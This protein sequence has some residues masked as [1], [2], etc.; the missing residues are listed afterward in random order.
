[1]QQ[2]SRSKLKKEG[3]SMNRFRLGLL[4]FMACVFILIGSA[5][6]AEYSGLW[7]GKVTINAVSEVNRREPDLSFD[8]GMIGV[9]SEN[10]FIIKGDTWNYNDA[11]SEPGIDGNSKNWKQTGYNDSSWSSGD[12]ALGYGAGEFTTVSYGPDPEQKYPTTYFRKCFTVDDP[13]AY[14][15]LNLY[16]WRDDGVIVYL[17]GEEVLRNNLSP[18]YVDFDTLA[19]S[20]ITENTLLQLTIPAG[21][22][23]E[24][25]NCIAAEVHLANTNDEDCLFDLKLAGILKDPETTELIPLESMDW[26][27]HHSQWGP[28]AASETDPMDTDWHGTAYDDNGWDTGQAQFGYG[29]GDETTELISGTELKPPTAYFRRAFSI[30]LSLFT[31]L[32]LLLLQDDG[33][34]VYINGHEVVRENL[35]S[36]TIT[37]TTPPIK[38]L[39]SADEN[40]YVVREIDLSGAAGLDLQPPPANNIVA[41]EVHQ[42]P[43]EFGD[44][45]AAATALTRTPAAFDLRLILHVDETGTA[46]LLKEVIQMYDETNEEL[47]LLTNHTL[48]P[49]YEGIP[50]AT[51][52]GERVGR[53]MSSIGFDFNGTS[54]GCSG[55]FNT[56]GSIACNFIL[57][58]DH[59]TNPFLHR[60]HPD[61]DN[62]DERYEE[63]AQE[64]YRIERSIKIDFDDR[65]PP[66]TD[67]AER[68]SP[69]GWSLDMLGGQYTETLK[70]L[71]KEDL[72]ISGYF[73]I[74]RV[75]LI[76]NIKE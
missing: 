32:R 50:D 51:R 57:E 43:S 60:Y 74:N 21:L 11:G 19:I 34:V 23:L 63:Y 18:S 5:W 71:H 3:I 36:E 17:N 10:T 28:G 70:G 52:D 6:A 7:V 47:V 35:P 9:K 61:H 37:H 29:E 30:D 49:Q 45:S 59:S 1:M 76:D 68:R 42:H 39:G 69:P 25:S 22:L 73:V 40:F 41:V 24:G 75:S 38:A 55:A 53:R 58:S 27:Y 44:A 46:R 67:K 31:H 72:T 64:S 2:L 33:S 54:I 66:D 13:G 62:L 8:L 16:V 4:A 20:E 56:T 26:K 65:Y 15:G 48:I 12:A 14:E